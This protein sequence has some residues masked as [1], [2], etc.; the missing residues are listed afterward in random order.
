LRP[1]TNHQSLRVGS[2]RGFLGGRA[3]LNRGGADVDKNS[4]NVFW[5][6]S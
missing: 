4:A 3:I 1:M 6:D 5:V 2:E